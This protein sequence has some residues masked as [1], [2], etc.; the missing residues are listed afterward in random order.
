MSNKSNQ[1][2]IPF[3]TP[4]I[5]QG[6]NK[7][8][9]P[10]K[11]FQTWKTNTVSS[12]IADTI[13][14]L[15]RM[16]PEYEYYFFS[17][18]DCKDYFISNY[19]EKYLQAF[20]HLKPGAFKADFWRY[21]VLAKEG[22]IYIDLDMKLTK[23]LR[24]IINPDTDF[25]VVKD[26]PD[27]AIYQAFI[28]VV[29]NHPVLIGSNEECFNNIMN[30][31][32]GDWVSVLSITGPVMMGK[33]YS[34]YYTGSEGSPIKDYHRNGEI[35]QMATN[36]NETV[37]VGDYPRGGPYPGEVIFRNK[38]ESY[39][40]STQYGSMFHLCNVYQGQNRFNCFVK[41]YY[42][43]FW[44]I[45]LIILILVTMKYFYKYRLYHVNRNSKV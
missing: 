3:Y 27:S 45:L 14:E 17:D 21:A 6:K 36:T 1:I 33:V 34:L 15:K 5:F 39:K 35:I 26:L 4:S 19:G 44:V 37:V 38:I 42:G 31:K 20:N 32:M 22:G 41:K 43:I 29:P 13:E 8:K 40:A 2:Y 18:Q 28:A 30:H 24:E 7:H 9:I 11:I 12:D 25:Y 10:L 23:P 16:N